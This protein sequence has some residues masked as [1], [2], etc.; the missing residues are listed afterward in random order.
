MAVI[1]AGLF[2]IEIVDAATRYRLDRHGIVPRSVDGLTG[3]LWAPLLHTDF[4][5]LIANVIPGA[6]LGFLLLMS[7]RFL[8]VTAIVWVISGL[9]VWLTAPPQSVT[10]GASGV[11][12][13]WLTY[14]LVRGIFNRD[15]WQVLI[16][17]VILV[18]YG[19]VL[20]GVLPSAG[21]VSWQ[22]HL[23]GAAGGVLAAWTLAGN[24]RR[25]RLPRDGRPQNEGGPRSLST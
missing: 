23:F 7:G 11:I 12:F 16:G 22:G 1:V 3:I 19:G 15:V 17:L 24:D 2:V 21:S 4:A 8:V 10:V 6:V 5:H 9:G 14:L 25:G 20:W 13:G 18:V